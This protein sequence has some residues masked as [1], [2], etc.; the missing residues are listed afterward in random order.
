MGG[1]PDGDA[2]SRPWLIDAAN[3]LAEPDPGPTPWLVENLIVDSALVACVGRWKTT[4]RLRA[5]RHLHC[6]RNRQT[7]PR[8]ARHP[9]PPDPSSS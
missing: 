2:T 9:N 3:L 6:R 7:R 1:W 4:K 5:A 8:R